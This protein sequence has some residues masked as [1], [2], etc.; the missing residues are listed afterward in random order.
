MGS[1]RGPSRVW[2]PKEI[3]WAYDLYSRGETDATVA[4]ILGVPLRTFQKQ[5]DSQPAMG[6]ARKYG[7][8]RYEESKSLRVEFED[9]VIGSLPP[10]LKEIWDRLKRERKE[11]P[12]SSN[13][14]PTQHMEMRE[15]QI[16][17]IHAWYTMRFDTVKAAKFIGI[18][19][20]QVMNWR[21]SGEFKSLMDGMRE[22]QKDFVENSLMS[23]VRMRNP[24][25][26]IFAAKTLLKDRGYSEETRVTGK[27]EHQHDVNVHAQIDLTDLDLPVD[28]QLM[29][30]EAIERREKRI[31]TGE[32]KVIE[33]DNSNSAPIPV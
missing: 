17:F 1:K 16:L 25:A 24:N 5:W 4:G 20:S 8:K 19:Y 30:M 12:S 7:R 27:I 13:I 18:S 11:G 14:Q 9:I 10:K 33:H 23:L 28:V 31:Q 6:A 32:L 15:K 26:T 22:L 3:F 29:V 21:S 2:K